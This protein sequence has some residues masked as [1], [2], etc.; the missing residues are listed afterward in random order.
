MIGVII[1]HPLDTIKVNLQTRGST[2][3]HYHGL[4]T[5]VIRLLDK[6]GVKA[7]YRGVSSPLVGLGVMNAV[8]FGIYG[9]VLRMMPDPDSLLAISVAGTASAI[10]TAVVISPVEMTK[11]RIQV[12]IMV[13]SYNEASEYLILFT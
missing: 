6:D 4:M 9:S 10:P 2:N 11:S 7:L 12:S 13:I 1:G 3:P 8:L 5:T